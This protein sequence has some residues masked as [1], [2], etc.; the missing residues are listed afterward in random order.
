MIENSGILQIAAS[1]VVPDA[2]VSIISSGLVG[3]TTVLCDRC[4]VHSPANAASISFILNNDRQANSKN[5]SASFGFYLFK[6]VRHLHSFKAAAVAAIVAD[7]T[8]SL[9][10]K[11]ISANDNHGVSGISVIDFDYLVSKTTSLVFQP[12]VLL[13]RN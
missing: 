8:W 10:T 13:K 3:T 9:S 5:S 4:R 6:R 11:K 1:L 12:R 7:I 2:N